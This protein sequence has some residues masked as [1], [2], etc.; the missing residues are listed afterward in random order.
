MF[1]RTLRALFSLFLPVLIASTLPAQNIPNPSFEANGSFSV[2]PGYATNNGGVITSWNMTDSGRTGINASGGA[3]FDNGLVPN[4]TYVC[5][6]QSTLG[7]TNILSNN[8]MGLAVGATYRVSFRANC[9]ANYAAPASTWSLNGAA[10]VP[11]TSWPSVNEMG[12]YFN[13]FYANSG[14][15]VATDTTA[16]MVL[17]NQTAADST[18]LLDNFT[19]TLIAPAP[20]VIT[21]AAE[22]TNTVAILKGLVNTGASPTTVW[23]EWGGM[24][25]TNTS[26]TTPI[27]TLNNTGAMVV[28]SDLSGLTP[29]LIYRQ[30][31]AASNAL[32]VTRGSFVPFASPAIKLQGPALTNEC[33][34]AFVFNDPGATAVGPQALLVALDGGERSQRSTQK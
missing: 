3:F 14:T 29:G 23:F 22:I 34:T 28:T 13:S 6:L 5:F 25:A 9:R 1:F 27:I 4:G 8:I 10:F 32:G 24:W 19:I 31:I 15:F 30:R 21:L 7:S 26:T 18:V 2:F 12:S 11:F 20:V 16:L 33:H 17:R